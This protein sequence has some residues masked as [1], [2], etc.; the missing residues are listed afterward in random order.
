MT[1]GEYNTGK[2][3][4]LANILSLS[5]EIMAKNIL[6]NDYKYISYL[7]DPILGEEN[8]IRC[9]IG[10]INYIL[11]LLGAFKFKGEKYFD[12][13]DIG[14]LSG[15]SNLGEEEI[16]VLFDWIDNKDNPLKNIII[17][18]SFYS[19]KD[20]DL[21]FTL[22][23]KFDLNIILAD[24]NYIDLNIKYELK[25]PTEPDV[26]DGTVVYFYTSKQTTNIRANSSWLAVAKVSDGDL[27][28]LKSN[29]GYC[30][31]A[32]VELDNSIKGT[33][34]LMAVDNLS[35]YNFKLVKVVKE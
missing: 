11:A 17:D 8:H 4:S 13:L 12:D 29:D 15:E 25:E 10:S 14:Y 30:I 24:S 6:Q 19:H 20:R 2:T 26:F 16:Q 32:T 22:L 23:K 9:E 33:V 35:G 1:F 18:S 5:N 27:I 21:I 31:K 28:T 3:L 34:A 7:S